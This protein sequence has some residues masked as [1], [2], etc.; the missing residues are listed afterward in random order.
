MN[1]VKKRLECTKD[2]VEFIASMNGRY[3]RKPTVILIINRLVLYQTAIYYKLPFRGL[4]NN[5]SRPRK[6]I[7]HIIVSN[8]TPPI[9]PLTKRLFCFTI[10]KLKRETHKSSTYNTSRI[11]KECNFS[12][13]LQHNRIS[14]QQKNIFT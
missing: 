4:G 6:V 10:W 1:D 11:C 8:R 2:T 13:P 5:L 14:W 3:H 12:I 7:L 9:T